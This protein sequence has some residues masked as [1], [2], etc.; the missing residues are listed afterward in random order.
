[1][2]KKNNEE[3]GQ[4]NQALARASLSRRQTWHCA[5]NCWYFKGWNHDMETFS[6]PE[7]SVVGHHSSLEW[8]WVALNGWLAWVAVSGLDWPNWP[9]ASHPL[10]QNICGPTEEVE[11]N[12][13]LRAK[14][15]RLNQQIT[16]EIEQRNTNQMPC[17]ADG[18]DTRPSEAPSDL[19]QD[20]YTVTFWKGESGQWLQQVH[21]DS[22]L[23]AP[24]NYLENGPHGRPTHATC[25]ARCLASLDA[26]EDTNPSLR[27]RVRPSSRRSCE[28]Q[29]RQLRR[30]RPNLFYEYQTSCST[31]VAVFEFDDQAKV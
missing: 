23:D 13:D 29:G 1:M 21:H 19:S 27:E 16:Q 18:D 3:T 15:A 9:I 20:G 4:A 8:P 25:I 22:W 6:W 26:S 2:G 24:R 14:V 12:R 10:K 30:L 28:G 17:P 7:R 31:A 11:V 5:S